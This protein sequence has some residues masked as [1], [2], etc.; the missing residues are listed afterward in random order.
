MSLEYFVGIEFHSGSG[1]YKSKPST[2][3][4]DAFE[5]AR[6][7]N[8][9]KYHRVTFYVKQSGE[10]LAIPYSKLQHLEDCSTDL[11]KELQ[12][13]AEAEFRP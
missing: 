9:R 1:E 6:T 2:S 4:S 8:S 13:L 7:G 10:I 3:A 11:E 5:M 12:K